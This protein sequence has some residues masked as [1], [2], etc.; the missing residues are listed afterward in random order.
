M[1][2]NKQPQTI[3]LYGIDPGSKAGK[4]WAVY[5]TVYSQASGGFSSPEFKNWQIN[6]LDEF[7]NDLIDR[8]TT[9]SCV[10]LAIDAPINSPGEFNPAYLSR[11]TTKSRFPFNTNPFTIRPCEKALRTKHPAVNCRHRELVGLLGQLCNWG[12]DSPGTPFVELDECQGVSVRIY[13]EAPH[14]PVVT[15]FRR[16]LIECSPNDVDVVDDP[17]FTFAPSTVYILEAHPAVPM[18]FWVLD[19]QLGDL[20]QVPK[21]KGSFERLDDSMAEKKKKQ[22]QQEMKGERARDLNRLSSE[23]VALAKRTHQLT[24][25]DPK[26][27]GDDNRLDAF[28]ALINVMDLADGKGDW[29]GT[30]RSG[31]FLTP[32]LEKL[33]GKLFADAWQSAEEAN[34]RLNANRA[35]V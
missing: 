13:S 22:K 26:I 8:T 34:I 27:N 18:G 3:H 2:A 11:T 35:G 29:F 24:T 30:T 23:I 9:E 14:Q 5:S 32:R 21:Y 4:D 6:R 25:L 12:D 19:R 17:T 31:Y 16:R 20:S 28:V 1:Q 10:I 7:I 33:G 15:V